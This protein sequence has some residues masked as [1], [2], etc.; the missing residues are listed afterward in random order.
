MNKE[1]MM[2]EAREYTGDIL[3]FL[4]ERDYSSAQNMVSGLRRSI[5]IWKKE[6]KKDE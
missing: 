3:K 1:Q 4:G 2:D 6:V 5:S